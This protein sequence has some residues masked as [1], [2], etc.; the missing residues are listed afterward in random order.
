MIR[1]LSLMGLGGGF[2]MISPELRGTVLSGLA[3]AEQTLNRYS[4]VSYV[5]LGLALLLGLVMSFR[6]GAQPR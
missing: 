4:P 5:V 6:Q 1:L 2:L 3:A